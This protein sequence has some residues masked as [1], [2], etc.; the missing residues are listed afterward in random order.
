MMVERGTVGEIAG[1]HG[2][3]SNA[4]AFLHGVDFERHVRFFLEGPTELTGRQDD[5]GDTFVVFKGA[6]EGHMGHSQL[7]DF[8]LAP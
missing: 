6:V 7:T 8:R 2:L 1:A 5:V 3:E 4:Q